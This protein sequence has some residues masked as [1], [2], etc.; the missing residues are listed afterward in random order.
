M[1]VKGWCKEAGNGIELVFEIKAPR[2]E[3]TKIDCTNCFWVAFKHAVEEDLYVF[4]I[5]YSGT[6]N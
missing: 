2:I 3:P 4:K 1:Q 5:S 6:N